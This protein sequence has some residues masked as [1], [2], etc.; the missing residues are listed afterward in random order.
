V[1]SLTKVSYSCDRVSDDMT[2]DLEPQS[3]LVETPFEE[4]LPGPNVIRRVGKN[5][6]PVTLV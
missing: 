4:Q 2:C 6:S 1:Y 5:H 3:A